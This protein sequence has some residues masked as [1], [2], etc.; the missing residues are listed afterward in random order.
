MPNSCLPS[1]KRGILCAM[2]QTMTKVKPNISIRLIVLL[3]ITV[4]MYLV[5]FSMSAQDGETS[6]GLS[7][8][9][10]ALIVSRDSASFSAMHHLVRKSAHVCEFALL[11]IM[12][13]GCMDEAFSVLSA[14]LRVGV[15]YAMTFASA[16]VDELH[17]LT[18]PGRSGQVTDVMIDM[19]GVSVL[20]LA[21]LWYY[22]RHPRSAE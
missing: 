13:F 7:E 9:L 17:Q 20:A 10:T 12:W 3:V 21:L 11:F 15:P 4:M 22:R 16:A 18:V 14:K 5:I 1:V 2:E 19:L 6:G 8:K